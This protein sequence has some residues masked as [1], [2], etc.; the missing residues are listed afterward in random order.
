M[1]PSVSNECDATSAFCL[2][3]NARHLIKQ[4]EYKGNILYVGNPE[5]SE[6]KE[7]NMNKLVGPVFPG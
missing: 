4:T 1:K 2:L 5:E 3:A 6:R 7:E